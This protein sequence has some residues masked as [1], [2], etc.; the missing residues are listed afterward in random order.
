[1]AFLNMS[2]STSTCPRLGAWRELATP[3][4]S[5]GRSTADGCSS[6]FFPN[7][8]QRYSRIC[9][10]ITGYGINRPDSFADR[11]LTLTVDENYL[12]GVSIT[13]GN[14]RQH[15]WSFAASYGDRRK[16]I[17]PC[18]ATSMSIVPNF[19]GEN[20][21]CESSRDS[22][23]HIWDGMGCLQ[24]RV[25]E[26]THNNPPWFCQ[27]LGGD[28]DDIMEIRICGDQEHSDEQTPVELVEIYVQ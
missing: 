10:R 4:R 22:D 17:C 24:N 11:E 20:Y 23:G 2:D 25:C 1:M 26:C 7:N 14:P 19:V 12:D 3:V 6:A 28:T 21:F 13:R 27:V 18:V 15:I 8:G 5:C 16:N 9:G